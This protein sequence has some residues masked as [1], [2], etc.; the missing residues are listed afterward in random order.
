MRLRNGGIWEIFVPELGP[1]RRT[2]TTSG[3]AIWATG[4]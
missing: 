1:G 3:P 2:N 4:S